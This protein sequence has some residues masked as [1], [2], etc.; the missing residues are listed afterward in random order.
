MSEHLDPVTG[1]L[2]IDVL[3]VLGDVELPKNG[4][5][6]QVASVSGDSW[7][8][9]EDAMVNWNNHHWTVLQADPSGDG[10]M[11]TNSIR[12]PGPVHGRRRRLAEGDVHALLDA[13]LAETGSLSSDL[14]RLSW[15]LEAM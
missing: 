1:W 9:G 10:W 11:H 12:G 4:H 14:L 15:L 8:L 2:S 13:I 7:R 3:N 6:L 5:G